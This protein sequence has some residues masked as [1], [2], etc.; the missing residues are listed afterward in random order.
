MTRIAYEVAAERPLLRIWW[1]DDDGDLIDFS[2]GYT[3]T[4][5][6][7]QLGSAAALTKTSGIT[8]SAGSGVPGDGTCNVEIAWSAGELALTP[9]QY[10]LQITAT[11]GGLDRVAVFPFELRPVIT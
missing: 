5:K 10:T 11:T 9:G 1:Q 7:G 8:G 6:V 2:S 4:V 3:F